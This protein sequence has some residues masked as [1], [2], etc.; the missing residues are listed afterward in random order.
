MFF[1]NFSIS[2]FSAHRL[3]NILTKINCFTFLLYYTL[4]LYV[5]YIC[6]NAYSM[7]P[8]PGFDVDLKDKRKPFTF[9][10]LIYGC[11]YGPLYL[12]SA[13]T[14]TDLYHSICCGTEGVIREYEYSELRVVRSMVSS[15]KHFTPGRVML[16]I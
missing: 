12:F 14:F 4:C 3:Q 9:V 16:L 7:R 11:Y 6:R 8:C 13:S 5:L 15:Q 2:S 10:I 1:T